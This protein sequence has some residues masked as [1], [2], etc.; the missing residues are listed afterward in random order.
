MLTDGDEYAMS[1]IKLL[2]SIRQNT[3]FDFDPIIISLPNKK[4]NSTLRTELIKTGWQI[5]VLTRIPPR[6]GD[7]AKTWPRFL[8]QFTKL[9]IWK[10]IEYKSVIYFD[11]DSFVIRN[12]DHLFTVHRQFKR[13]DRIGVTRDIFAGEWQSNFN[14]GIFVIKPNVMEH[15]RLMRLK[16]DRKRVKFDPLMSEQGFLNVVY[17][18]R[19]HEIGFEYNANLAVYAQKR[20]FWDEREKNIRVIHYTM[21]KPWACTLEYQTICNI[22]SN[23]TV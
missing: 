12:I 10:M 2:A 18:N 9:H 17:K 19:W 13:T 11:S 1:A 22:W 23:F 8:D 16:E 20:S 3:H 5:C 4:I 6:E 7:E 21:N 15:A 14:M